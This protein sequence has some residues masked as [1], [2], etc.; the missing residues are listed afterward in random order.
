MNK[1][2][3]VARRE[4]LYNLKRPAFLFSAFGTPLL[5][6]VVMVIISLAASGDGVSDLNEWGK[7]GYV[8]NST[9]QV[10]TP[11]AQPEGY[12]DL[13]VAY[14]T[15]DAA[16][17]ALDGGE[18]KAYVELPTAY[19]LN[20]TV[21]LYTY[22]DTPDILYSTIEQFVLLNLTAGQDIQIPLD[23][24]QDTAELTVRD[25]QTGEEVSENA[26]FIT[27]F[28]PVIFGFLMI[29]ASMTTS[30]FLM[31]GLVEERTSRII[32]ILVTSITPMQLLLGKI[33]GLGLLGLVQVGSLLGAALIGLAVGNNLEFLQGISLPADLA[34]MSLVYFLLTYFLLAALM[35][36]LGAL[37]NSEQ[38][39]RQISGFLT[40]PIMI[41]YILFV[42]F[43]TDPNGTLPMI[44]SFIPFTAPMAILIR[45]GLTDV[46]TWQIL[47]SMGSMLI[48]ILLVIWASARIFRWG[49]LLY[50]KRFNLR[51]ILRVIFSRQTNV[52]T[53]VATTQ[54]QAS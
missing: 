38:E 20:G 1:I 35:A 30:S 13:F 45:M 49:L 23:R 24:I 53:S 33:L 3:L 31:T 32:E 12:T 8:D 39:S 6:L 48:T 19:L 52:A 51:E 40:I 36:A 26:V 34:I 5:I 54:E 15:T 37:S 42:V 27:L 17:T 22:E 10:L 50:G 9:T 11:G 44:L 28:L 14:E 41:P 25:A 2:W 4:F 47:A 43:I 7:V 21:N 46:P 18:I 16:Q 29:M